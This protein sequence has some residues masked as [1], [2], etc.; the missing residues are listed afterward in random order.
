MSSAGFEPTA[1][2]LGNRR[3]IHLSYED[4]VRQNNYFNYTILVCLFMNSLPEPDFKYLSL[5]IASV[6]VDNSSK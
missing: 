6:L 1:Y 3:S 2:G 4:T 5:S